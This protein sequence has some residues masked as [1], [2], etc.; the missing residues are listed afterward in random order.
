MNESIFAGERIYLTAPEPEKDAEIISRW[1][2]DPEFHR[3]LYST[4]VRPLAPSQIQK[5]LEELEKQNGQTEFR[6]AVRSRENNRLLGLVRL[7]RI[8]WTSRNAMLQIAIGDPND[9]SRGYGREIFKLILR[10]AFHELNLYRIGAVTFEYNTRA[11]KLLEKA[12]FVLETRQREAIN[13]AG[14]RWDAFHWGKLIKDDQTKIGLTS[15]APAKV[16]ADPVKSDYLHHLEA[17]SELPPCYQIDAPLLRGQK[18]RLSAIDPKTDSECFSRWS[19]DGEYLRL[20]DADPAVPKTAGAIAKELEENQGSE[21]DFCFLVRT[22][23]DDQPIGAAEL[24]G[25]EWANG[26][27]FL[28]VGLGD[29]E[30]WNQ[31]YGTDAIRILLQFAFTELNLH[32]VS[33]TVFANN[34][35]A[36]HVYQKLGFTYEGRAREFVIRDGQRCD[37]IFMGILQA[38]WKPDR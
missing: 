25:I 2:H 6:M 35:R 14:R 16:I 15:L 27:A 4:T 20:Y 24:D 17:G 34:Q 29:R 10:Y 36:I 23:D 37:M 13:R 1:T 21:S 12:F 28:S 22:L 9:R 33:L 11:N 5:E 31:G 30:Y 32:R 19:Q 26:N 18:T 38:D 7:Y 8:L 3:L